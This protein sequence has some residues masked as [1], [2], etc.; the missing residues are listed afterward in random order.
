MKSFTLVCGSVSVKFVPFVS[1]GR[2]QM[3]VYTS[4][5]GRCTQKEKFELESA[6]R[7]WKC[8]VSQGYIHV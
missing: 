7:M 3:L 8:L 1:Y 6:R 4:A 2:K 5:D